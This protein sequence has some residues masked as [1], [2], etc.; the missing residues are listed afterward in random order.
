[1]GL[2]SERVG[3]AGG[4]GEEEEDEEDMETHIGRRKRCQQCRGEEKAAKWQ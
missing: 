4:R 1:M 3:D 2:S